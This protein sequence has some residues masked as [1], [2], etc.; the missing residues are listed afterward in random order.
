MK[1]KKICGMVIILLISIL[2]LNDNYLNT[3]AEQY[4]KY[5]FNE[6]EY[7]KT[8]DVINRIA[9]PAD[10][11]NSEPY[12]YEM[13]VN[14]YDLNNKYD[15]YELYLST[16]LIY[17]FP[18]YEDKDV[19]WKVNSVEANSYYKSLVVDLYPIIYTEPTLNVEC[20]NDIVETDAKINCD[21]KL[22]YVYDVKS[23]SFKIKHDKFAISDFTGANS[24]NS[25]IEDENYTL[26]T[27]NN[28]S[29]NT[30]TKTEINTSVIAT[31]SL[32][33]N[34]FNETT[35]FS[36]NIKIYN[37]DYTDELIKDSIEETK[38]TINIIK[39]EENQ[40]KEIVE[41]TKTEQEE[42]VEETK[43]EIVEKKEVENPPTG[44]K[45]IICGIIILIVLEIFLVFMSKKY[46]FFQK[47]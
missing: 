15:T 38:T 41:E 12:V 34:D 37:I 7:Y 27:E 36:D 45:S 42:I 19:M 30:G 21:L 32:K 35:N 22:K 33:A 13:Y 17:T 26:E 29:E 20:D 23:I 11:S 28:N 9:H 4:E 46:K 1:V 31:F 44:Y 6:G 47:I 5:T 18:K 14:Y 8:G 2:Y 40:E 39:K 25:T 43:E 24:W 16:D 3:M 10:D